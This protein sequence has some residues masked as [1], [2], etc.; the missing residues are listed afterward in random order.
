MY[1]LFLFTVNYKLSHFTIIDSFL[2]VGFFPSIRTGAIN[3]LSRRSTFC[4][5]YTERR[6]QSMNE[7]LLQFILWHI[8]Y[9]TGNGTNCFIINNITNGNKEISCCGFYFHYIRLGWNS[10]SLL[11]FLK[12]KKNIKKTNKQKK[13]DLIGETRNSSGRAPPRAQ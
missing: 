7:L 10:F 6:R 2:L 3:R 4:W 13:L 9:S 5:L 8:F 11:F 1:Y 12:K